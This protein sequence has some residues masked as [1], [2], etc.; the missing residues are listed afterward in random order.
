[1]RKT[2]KGTRPVATMF[3]SKKPDCARTMPW[4]DKVPLVRTTAA[5]DRPRAAS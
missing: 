4:V 2:T 3:Q 5:T 1:M